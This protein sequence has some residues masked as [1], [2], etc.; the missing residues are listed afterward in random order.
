MTDK[1]EIVNI[2]AKVIAEQARKLGGLVTEASKPN[3]NDHFKVTGRS[4]DREE[5]LK[6]HD[7]KAGTVHAVGIHTY[8][9]PGDGTTKSVVQGQL[10]KHKVPAQAHELIHA[11]MK[12]KYYNN[13]D[14][15]DNKKL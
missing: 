3:E 2:Y 15:Y 13:S 5:V 1:N 12:R 14:D 6:I 11:H 10:D 9:M 8:H 4:G 7:K